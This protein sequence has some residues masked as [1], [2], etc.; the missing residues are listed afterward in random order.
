VTFGAVLV[1]GTEFEMLTQNTAGSTIAEARAQQTLIE[2]AFSCVDVLGRP[3]IERMSDR[4]RLAGGAL[5]ILVESG[6]RC[7]LPRGVAESAAIRVASDIFS[8]I[9]ETLAEFSR[10]G[11]EHAFVCSA[12]SYAEADL[13]DMFYF[14]RAARKPVTQAFAG[15]GVLPLWV[16]DCAAAQCTNLQEMLTSRQSGSTGVSY[17]IREYVIQ[18]AHPRDLRQ[19]AVDMLNGRCEGGPSGQEVRPGIWLDRGAELHRGARIVAP[20]YVGRG[21]KVMDGTLITRSSSIE[22]DCCVDCG[23]VIENSSLLNGTHVG[24]W[25]DVCHALVNGDR[26]LSLERDVT[27]QISDPSIL[28][29]APSHRVIDSAAR[30]DDD[31]SE[32][33]ADIESQHP[34]PGAWQFGANLIQE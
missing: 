1:V 26:I 16:V 24:I 18:L 34:T 27:V 11:I 22:Q 8:A 13:L 9:V 12:N 28:R 20:A 7:A 29:F 32:A 30:V 6:E 3:V 19:L 4:I 21:S 15:D 17:F 10:N 5:A 33:A 31:R 25:L 2:E 23:T 14:H